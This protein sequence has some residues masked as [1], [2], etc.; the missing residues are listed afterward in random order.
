MSRKDFV[1]ALL[2][3]IIWGANFT[4]IKLGLEGVPPMLLVTLR[5]LLTAL[6]AVFFVR[7]P[8][9]NPW[10]WIGYGATVGIG[11]FGCLFYA[12]HIGMPAGIASV[13][14]Q[15]QAFFTLILGV[16]FLHESVS[17]SQ[18]A[19]LGMASVGLVM[20]GQT[21]E[22]TDIR[23]IPS[24]ALLLTLA[25]AAFWGVAN[26]IVRKIAVIAASQGQPIKMPSL[27]VW[28][29][30]VPRF[31]S[32]CWRSHWILPR[33][34]SKPWQPSMGSPYLQSFILPLGQLSSDLEYGA[35][36]CRSIPQDELP[37]C[38]YLSPSLVY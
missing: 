11:Q 28:S 6:P 33:R 14:L 20:V 29:S 16:V 25:G 31:H 4:V 30:L 15:S 32:A 37:R 2:V 18:L 17:S 19:G 7:R 38:H 26:L 1:L 35:S 22:F 3:V 10:Y 8:V 27:I 21:H 13:V 23:T 5:Y 9:V 36:C 34:S 12:M 24:A